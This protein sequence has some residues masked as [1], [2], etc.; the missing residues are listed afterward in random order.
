[1]LSSISF[2]AS[3]TVR[4]SPSHSSKFPLIRDYLDL[5]SS[6][7]TVRAIRA[8]MG[9]PLHLCLMDQLALHVWRLV[10][11]EGEGE[12]TGVRESLYLFTRGWILFLLSV[13]SLSYSLRGVCFTCRWVEKA[14]FFF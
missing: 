3:S 1:M 12:K 9:K 8:K 10:I 2:M 14:F 5:R 7:P 13:S 11:Q 6:E 4:L